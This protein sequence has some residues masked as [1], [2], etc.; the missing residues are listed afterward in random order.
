MNGY[1]TWLADVLRASGVQVKEIDGW[2]TRGHYGGFTGLRA[3]VWHHDASAVGDSPGVPSYMLGNWD[4]AAAQLW[5]D[6]AGVW[7]ILAAGP[8]YHAGKVLAGKPDN[9]TSLGVETDHTTGEEWPVALLTSLRIGTAAILKH[10]GEDPSTGL[11]FHKTIC[12]PKGRKSD[13]DGLDLADERKR[14]ASALAKPA[15][16]VKKAPVP[17]PVLKRGDMGDR[18]KDVQRALVKAGNKDLAVNGIFDAATDLVLRV[19]QKN[20][21]IP[22][23]GT[24]DAATWAALRV[25]AH[26]S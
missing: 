18:V 22:Q 10:L 2:K 9:H 20:R 5:V 3:V 4:T 19:F 23:T 26:G 16:A 6:R 12:S 21:G 13:P 24:T 17:D 7:H 15:P 8:A 25:V 14:V 1:A 11:E